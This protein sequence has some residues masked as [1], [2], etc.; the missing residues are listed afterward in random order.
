MAP[1]CA[2]G[3]LG[4]EKNEAGFER[5]GIVDCYF[6]RCWWLATFKR[7]ERVFE[8]KGLLCHQVLVARLGSNKLKRD[9]S[10]SW[11][12]ATFERTTGYLSEKGYYVL[13]RQVLMALYGFSI[14]EDWFVWWLATLV[15]I[16][17]GLFME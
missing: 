11:W 8:R 2:G 14:A 15:A 7:T 13:C 1:Q 16:H 4:L 5:E 3:S 12:F 17:R 10:V 6:T 9:M